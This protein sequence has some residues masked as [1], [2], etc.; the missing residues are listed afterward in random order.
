MKVNR[1]CIWNGNWYAWPGGDNYEN[2]CLT[3]REVLSAKNN[4]SENQVAKKFIRKNI[5]SYCPLSSN[6][7]G[8]DITTH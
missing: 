1:G 6:N 8:N 2:S 3:S 7:L 5:S 4:K